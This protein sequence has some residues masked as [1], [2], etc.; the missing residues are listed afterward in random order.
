[1]RCVG[2]APPCSSLP[3]L[4][5]AMPKF[6]PELIVF[7]LDGTLAATVPDIAAAANRAL[8]ALGLPPHSEAAIQEM[9][10]GGERT[11][12]RRALGAAHQ[13][14]YDQ[15][16]ELYLDYYFRHPVDHTRLYPGVRETL[17]ALAP[18]KLA[19]LSNK[20]AELTVRI[21]DLLG[22]AGFFA[23]VRGGDSY[24]ALKPDPAGLAALMHE[25]GATPGDTLMVGDKPADVLAG[26]AAGTATVA[27]TYGYGRL[28]DLAAAGP[29][30]LLGRLP[31]L[32]AL[33]A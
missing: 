13:D 2:G 29:D 17:S 33:L 10:G 8:A 21:V 5:Q 6:A 14:L 25:L 4:A 19:L 1:M 26:K 22:L 24:A 12:L 23:A 11:F 16:R 3:H 15:A 7:D 9:I 28:P 27:V 18:R 32:L 30:A 20:L 31:D